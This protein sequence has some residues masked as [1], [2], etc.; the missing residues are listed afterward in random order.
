[1]K[2]SN[3]IAKFKLNLTLNHVEL[4]DKFFVATSPMDDR[5]TQVCLVLSFAMACFKF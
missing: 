1:V 3:E 2:E 4:A 5:V